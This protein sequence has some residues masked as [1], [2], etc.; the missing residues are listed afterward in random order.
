MRRDP[1]F[2]KI[3]SWRRADGFGL[4]NDPSVRV[5]DRSDRRELCKSDLKIIAAPER[6]AGAG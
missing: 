3:L 4:P 2:R 1:H 6:G 5:G